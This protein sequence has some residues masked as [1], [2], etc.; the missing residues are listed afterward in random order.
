[1]KESSTSPPRPWAWIKCIRDMVNTA[2][3]SNSYSENGID[4]PC[5]VGRN[6]YISDEAN[7]LDRK[8]L[9]SLG[10]THV[11]SLNAAPPYRYR[12]SKELYDSI[13]IANKR[14]EA[15]DSEGY[16]M[17]GRHWDE[18]YSFLK[19]AHKEEDAKVVIH[20]VSGINRSGLII[21]AAVMIFE[22]RDVVAVVDACIK[23]RRMILWNKSF[24]EQLCM[25]AAKYELLGE[26]PEGY[27]NEPVVADPLPPPPIKAFDRLI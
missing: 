25:L 1:M 8:K 24:Q 11:L 9:Q 27:D 19:E 26:K 3:K 2:R 20:C 18:C 5:Q 10:I 23:K 6:L 22:E 15:E 12:W 4:L 13:N 14:I 21:C 16:D 7:A 17:I